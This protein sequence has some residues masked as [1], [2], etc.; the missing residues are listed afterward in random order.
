MTQSN[1]AGEKHPPK[2]HDLNVQVRYVA[3]AAPFVDKVAPELTLAT[4][5]PTVLTHFGLVEGNVDGGS[6]VYNFTFNKTVLTDLSV[7]LG[8]LAGGDRQVKLG[9]VEQLIQG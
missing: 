3:V 2:E 7:T 4:F 9:L 8:S 5:K 1:P 6:K